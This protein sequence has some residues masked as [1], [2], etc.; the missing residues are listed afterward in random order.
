MKSVSTINPA[1]TENMERS[2]VKAHTSFIDLKVGVL[3]D[4]DVSL[5]FVSLLVFQTYSATFQA[6]N[7]VRSTLAG[8]ALTLILHRSHNAHTTNCHLYAAVEKGVE[9]K[10]EQR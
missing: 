1:M 6:E 3:L 10:G 2:I 8:S 9:L 4:H 7:S 5:R